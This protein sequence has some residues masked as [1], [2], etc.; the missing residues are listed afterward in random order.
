MKYQMVVIPFSG[1]VYLFNQAETKT[2]TD[3]N[4]E[5]NDNQSGRVII[6]HCLI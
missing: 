3:V 5:S 1:L 4:I 2:R 6:G